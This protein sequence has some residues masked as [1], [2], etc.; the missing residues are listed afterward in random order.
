M[1]LVTVL[2]INLYKKTVF[3]PINTVLCIINAM[4]HTDAKSF[5]TPMVINAYTTVWPA[6][7]T[8]LC[9]MA[10]VISAYQQLIQGNS[11]FQPSVSK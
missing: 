6:K 7:E 9:N 8:F 2:N 5:D 11:W 4:A 10:T 3:I 1:E